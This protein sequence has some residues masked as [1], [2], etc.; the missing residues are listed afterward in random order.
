MVKRTNDIYYY[1]LVKYH[2][3][4]GK[5]HTNIIGIKYVNVF[6]IE[7]SD[8]VRSFSSGKDDNIFHAM[9]IRI[10]TPIIQGNV[11]SPLSVKCK[12]GTGSA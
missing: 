1:L 7:F 9:I 4:N 6:A 12:E 10:T 2:S 8:L 11:S 5:P 3:N